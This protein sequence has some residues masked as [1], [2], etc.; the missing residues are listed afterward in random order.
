MESKS[1]GL[2]IK[3]SMDNENVSRSV[4]ETFEW[5]SSL[6]CVFCLFFYNNFYNVFYCFWR[7]NAANFA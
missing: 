1:N 4:K 3:G 2:I 5:G 7:I 6:F